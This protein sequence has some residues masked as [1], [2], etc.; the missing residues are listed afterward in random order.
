M[1]ADDLPSI[2]DMVVNYTFNAFNPDTIRFLRSKFWNKSCALASLLDDEESDPVTGSAE[3]DLKTEESYS[4]AERLNEKHFQYQTQF[5]GAYVITD[6]PELFPDDAKVIKSKDGLIPLEQASQ[7]V[8]DKSH[9]LHLGAPICHHR[10]TFYSLV[11]AY[12]NSSQTGQGLNITML[13]DE[14]LQTSFAESDS[15]NLIDFAGPNLN[16]KQKMG[17]LVRFIERKYLFEFDN[18][19][20]RVESCE[21]VVSPAGNPNPHRSGSYFEINVISP[22]ITPQKTQQRS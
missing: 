11:R 2:D 15:V 10:N 21:P 5:N 18:Y 14:V 8:E 1:Q 19:T 16:N 22:Q 6:C 17:E 13:L 12:Q 7:L 3:M 9:I 20:L 4:T